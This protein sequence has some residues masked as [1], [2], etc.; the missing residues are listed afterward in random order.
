MGIA[1][2]SLKHEE[3]ENIGYVIPTPVRT[4]AQ[5]L[6]AAAVA[7]MQNDQTGSHALARISGT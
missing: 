7:V 1:F 5:P 6:V 2:Q 3:A 4:Q